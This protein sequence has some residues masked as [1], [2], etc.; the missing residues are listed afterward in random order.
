MPKSLATAALL[1][2]SSLTLPAFSQALPQTLPESPRQPTTGPGANLVSSS[3]PFVAPLPDAA[4]PAASLPDAP[5]AS[6]TAGSPQSSSPTQPAALQPPPVG[7]PKQTTRILGII[8]NFRSV[9][10]GTILPPQAVKEKF[11]TGLADSFDYS[12]FVFVGIQAGIAQGTDSYPVFH[13]GAAGFARY[14]WHTFADQADE[15]LMAESI[16]PAALHED[17]RYYTLEHGGF[18]KRSVYALSRAVIT[19]TDSGGETLNVAEIGGAGSAAAISSLYYPSQYLTWTKVGQ[20][21]LTNVIL[22]TATLYVKEFWPDVNSAL[23]HK[24]GD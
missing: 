3:V 21:W 4:I 5:Q 20:R 1:A 14:Y 11:K 22:D 15:N 10:A 24:R 9:S 8:P 16:F 13:Q 17:S 2:V 12:A 18:V 6:T 19:R 23:S 7:E